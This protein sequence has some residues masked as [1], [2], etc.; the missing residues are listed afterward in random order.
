MI[1]DIY[2]LLKNNKSPN[3]ATIDIV[4]LIIAS[5]DEPTLSGWICV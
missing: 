3:I 4:R 5:W 1:A 2:C